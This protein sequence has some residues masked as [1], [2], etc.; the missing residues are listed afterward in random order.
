[1]TTVGYGDK[2]P[3]TIAGR[4]VAL[5]WMFASIIIIS[6]ITAA[7]ASALTVSQLST[8]IAGPSDLPDVRVA[9][10]AGTTSEKYLDENL[11]QFERATETPQAALQ[12]LAAGEVDAVV[13]DAPVLRYL[14][15]EHHHGQLRVLPREFEPQS[16]AIAMPSGTARLEAINRVILRHTSETEWKDMVKR[17]LGETE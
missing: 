2:A 15:K 10:V 4:L 3:V 16:Y 8:G 5:V 1:M 13:Y 17:Y 7:I 14:V 9:T 11:I 6:G 12:A